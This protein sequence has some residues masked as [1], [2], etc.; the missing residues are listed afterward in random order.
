MT[1]RGLKFN[2]KI[3]KGS[4]PQETFITEGLTFCIAVLLPFCATYFMKYDRINSEGD[5][6][7]QSNETK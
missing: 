2:F 7:I 1:K 5:Y 3:H 4:L 6:P